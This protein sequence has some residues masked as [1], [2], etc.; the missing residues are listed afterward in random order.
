MFTPK[1]IT[2]FILLITC[3]AALLSIPTA[4]TQEAPASALSEAVQADRRVSP[5]A[6]VRDFFNAMLAVELGNTERLEEAI[7][8][9][10]LGED[11]SDDERIRVGTERANRLFKVLNTL[12]FKMDSIPEKDEA[13]AGKLDVD[14]GSNGKSITLTLRQ[15]DDGFW[16]FHSSTLSDEK[17]NALQE[18]VTEEVPEE[19]SEATLQM[20]EHLKSPRAAVA[21][22][23]ACMDE[24]EG[25]TRAQAL[26]AMDLSAI[27][28]AMRQSYGG[29]QAGILKF[30]LDRWKLIEVSEL[31]G[32]QFSEATYVLLQET[33]G[34]IALKKVEIE[35]GLWAW[36]F[37]EG[38][39]SEDNLA[40]LQD[41]FA[42][43]DVVAGLNQSE[44][45]LPLAARIR[46]FVRRLDMPILMEKS[47]YLE[48]WHWLG[49][50]I[51]IL[52]GMVVS[53][54]FT[55]FLSR[56]LRRWFNQAHFRLD[57][58]LEKD[59]VRP[60]RIALM[61]WFWLLGLHVLQLPLRALEVLHLAAIVVSTIGAIWA[62]YK[63]IDIAG[64]YMTKRAVKT[65]NKFDDLLAPIIVRSLKVLLIVMGVVT[66]SQQQDRYELSAVLTG[67][68]LGGLAF[69]LAAKD[70]VAN[71]FGSITII[72]DRPFELGDW[73]TIGSVD[74]NVES[75]GIR[76]TRI[77]TFYNS[78][79]SVP[80]ADVVNTPIDNWGKRKFRRIKTH[81][82]LTYDT[83]PDKIEAFCEGV[84]EL[85]RQHP[86]TRKD[87]FH[88]Y[89]HQ[90]S[91]SSLD[92]LLYCFL[93]T[94]EWNTELRERHRLFVDIIRL[95]NELGV[96]F[97]F[98]TQTLFMRED[99]NPEHG[100][101]Q[102]PETAK[103]QGIRIAENITR[104]YTGAPGIVP[105]PVSFDQAPYISGEGEA[106]GDS[107]GE[108][109]E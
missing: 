3:I 91:A 83:P 30:V 80:N 55:F 21:W 79:I 46:L 72:I 56:I 62:L 104:K 47:L 32:E 65:D 9:L 76:S 28:T 20:V 106:A 81:L 89:L 36:Q 85:I 33:K 49:L 71:F 8:C 43:R 5:R 98:P 2:P 12:E 19:E 16:R 11:L 59:F 96:E 26:E 101:A 88:V 95:A 38:S 74:G 39:L 68:G 23:L 25:L 108:N 27:T 42:D 10:Y 77:R 94:P 86:Y 102:P 22:F 14:L 13:G 45:S 51:V 66:I 69:A 7:D 99:Q 24:E 44:D 78:L 18:Q 90:F 87:Y 50:F 35:E 63:L 41:A 31:P 40:K 60:I 109:V 58:K 103:N 64:A 15:Y 34:R 105:P 93:I 75:V 37:S 1:Y 6:T 54:I 4:V 57:E 53:R 84:R 17:L 82:S 73:V 70:V 97:A 92:V 107:S 100:P 61:A 29:Q 67:L 48:N 52:M